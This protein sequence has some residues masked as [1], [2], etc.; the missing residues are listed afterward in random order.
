M[1]AA[2]VDLVEGRRRRAE[3]R[4]LDVLRAQPGR[5]D[6]YELLAGNYVKQGKTAAAIEKVPRPRRARTGPT[7]PATMVGILLES[8][9]DQ[10]SARSQ[11]EA[12]LAKSPR[13]AVAANNLAWMLAQEGKYDEA[14]RWAKVAVEYLPFASRAAGHARLDSSQGQPS[15]RGARRVREGAVAG[16]AERDVPRAR[17]RGEGGG[18]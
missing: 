7:G 9:G 1:L 11:Y 15:N 18:R 2:R 10:S 17:R 12:V 13:A 3:Q 6:A 4:L 5:L 8:T 14:M 16:A